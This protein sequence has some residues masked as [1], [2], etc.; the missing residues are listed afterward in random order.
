[1]IIRDPVHGDIE[2]SEEERRVLDTGAMQRLRA[3]K[4]LGAAYL[5][6]PGCVHTRFDHSLGTLHTASRVID[7]L[8]RRGHAVSPDDAR[9]VR[10]S[11]LVH[12]VSHIPFGHT[13]EDERKVFPRHDTPERL[14]RFLRAGEL[15]DLLEELGL[16]AAVYELLTRPVDWR[17]QIVS[18]TLDADL[19]DYLRRDAYFAGLSQGYDDRIYHYFCIESGQL[20]VDLTKRGLERYDARSE[21]VHL[22]RL[23]YF[24]TERVYFHHAKVIAGA[25]V[26]KAL[27]L[28]TGMGVREED[29]Y[30]KGDETLLAY[31]EAVGR[32]RA[33]PSG[34]GGAVVELVRGVRRRRLYKRAYVLTCAG[35][36]PAERARLVSAYH[37]DVENRRRL[38]EEIAR[39]AGVA[40]WDVIVYCPA[41]TALK[42]ASV[43]ARRPWGVERLDERRR[44]LELD[45]IAAQYEQIWR[46]WVFARPGVEEAVGRAAEEALG[47]PSELRRRTDRCGPGT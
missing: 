20:A 35:V 43:L 36:S 41:H 40:P 7:A 1:M 22:L 12:D 24:L 28:A 46:F 32:E 4:Q 47:L 16:G 34:D 31:L 9:L 45:A 14:R 13:F 23:R 19:L 25:M 17:G 3:I 38:E 6:Y 29:L 21:I 27:E 2:I 33:G 5:V 42:E 39:R 11:A 26:S 10:M 15:G 8:R 30:D 44:D 37:A 18:G